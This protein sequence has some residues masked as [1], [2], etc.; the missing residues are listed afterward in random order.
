MPCIVDLNS[1]PTAVIRA[2]MSPGT[3]TAALAREAGVTLRRREPSAGGLRGAGA[4]PRR[5][6]SH[7]SDDHEPLPAGIG[8]HSCRAGGKR[9]AHGVVDNQQVTTVPFRVV[10]LTPHAGPAERPTPGPASARRHRVS[11]FFGR[12]YEPVGAADTAD[13]KNWL[14]PQPIHSNAP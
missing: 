3:I 4:G 12:V 14:T 10:A 6:S 7:R 1:R 11:S 2:L 8:F 5:R 13:E 9:L